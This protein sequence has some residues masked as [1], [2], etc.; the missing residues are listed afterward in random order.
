MRI[1]DPVNNT[2]YKN[3]SA[4]KLISYIFS[5]SIFFVQKMKIS[6]VDEIKKNQY[7]FAS[8]L[9]TKYFIFD[10]KVCYSDYIRIIFIIKIVIA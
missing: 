3:N 7:F 2:L 4:R 5:L 8:H 6:L 1:N 10:Y 9:S